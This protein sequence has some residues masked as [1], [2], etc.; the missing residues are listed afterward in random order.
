MERIT[1]KISKSGY[2]TSEK[3]ITVLNVFGTFTVNSINK[4]LNKYKWK[5]CKWSNGKS[6][7]KWKGNRKEC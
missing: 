5:G 3:T 1:V 2:V 6:L 4:K 7:C